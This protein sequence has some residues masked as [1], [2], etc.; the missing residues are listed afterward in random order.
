MSIRIATVEDAEEMDRM[1]RLVLPEN[2]PVEFWRSVIDHHT[3]SNFII[4]EDTTIENEEG[5]HIT[6][7]KAVAYILAIVKYN[8]Q[9][10]L[11]GHVY[12]IGVLP[13]HRRK[14]YGK[15]LL[16]AIE[17]DFQAGWQVNSV[18]LHCR[19]DN[20]NAISFYHKCGY[21]RKKKVKG[22]YGKGNDGLLM[23]HRLDF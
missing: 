12:S 21:Q 6:K 22:Y 13:E 2:Y 15:M 4:E 16:E 23:E 17:K 20:K 9:K 14:G 5:E 3:S 11:I 19:K 18:T 10:R 8:N 7:K 1:N